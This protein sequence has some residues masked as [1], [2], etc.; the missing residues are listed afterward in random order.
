M[1][2]IRRPDQYLRLR[3][4]TWHY[5]RRVPK[6]VR[7]L[8]NRTLIYRSLDIDSRKVARQRR[9]ICA[10]EDNQRW[11]ELMPNRFQPPPREASYRA[12][13][14]LA[15]SRGC[16]YKPMESLVS[17]DTVTDLLHR[18]IALEPLKD[19]PQPKEERDADALLGSLK[20]PSVT[21]TEAMDLYLSEIVADELSNKP[22]E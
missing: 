14:Q 22:P 15:R 10:D 2:A 1:K 4:D 16:N 17:Q 19:R 21:I 13:S 11:N 20:T 6:A 9:D 3:G 8:D 5:V 18:L 12:A 7:H